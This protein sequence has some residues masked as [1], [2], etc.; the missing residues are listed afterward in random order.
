MSGLRKVCCMPH[1]APDDTKFKYTFPQW[2]NNDN[3]LPEHVIIFC[4]FYL[5]LL[6]MFP[7]LINSLT[8]YCKKLNTANIIRL[9]D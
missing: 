9:Q 6:C 8:C 7:A 3:V 5:N 2:K 4:K 1:C